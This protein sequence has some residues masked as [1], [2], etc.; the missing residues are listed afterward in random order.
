MSKAQMTLAGIIQG[1]STKSRPLG[2]EAFVTLCALLSGWCFDIHRKG[3]SGHRLRSSAKS[4]RS[5]SMHSF[6]PT[7]AGVWI[8]IEDFSG[9]QSLDQ[10][11]GFG[12]ARFLWLRIF[13][14]PLE[15]GRLLRVPVFTNIIVESETKT[16]QPHHLSI[17]HDYPDPNLGY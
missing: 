16:F 2:F 1:Y 6:R 15:V 8:Y 7:C 13:I 14:I 3:I 10:E 4:R 17:R 9:L 5:A 12:S 11:R